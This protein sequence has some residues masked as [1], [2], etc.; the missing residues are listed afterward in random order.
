[1]STHH[2][3]GAVLAAQDV[4]LV[5]QLAFALHAPHEGLAVARVPVQRAGRHLVQLLRRAVAQQV[6]ERGIGDQN[7]AVARGLVHA[8]HHAFEQT[9]KFRLAVAQ[10][11]L[12]AAALDGDAGDLRHARHQLVI[13]RA[14]ECPA[15]ADRPRRC[16]PPAPS[17]A[18]MGVDHAARKR[19]MLRRLAAVLPQ[20]IGVDVGDGD[21]PRQ[22]HRGG[23]GAE[24]DADGRAVHGRDELARQIRRRRRN[25][26]P[27]AR[28]RAG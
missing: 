8:L 10:R 18:T 16:R 23:A 14:A 24:A 5:A 1:M 27:A 15:A 26:T 9:A 25:S 21:L 6:H 12:G 22:I 7:A 20:R 19:R 3:H 4:L 13:L 2:Q 17:E 11:I 28:D